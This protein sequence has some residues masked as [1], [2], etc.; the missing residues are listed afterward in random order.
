MAGRSADRGPGGLRRTVSWTR[1][2][3]SFTPRRLDR[4]RIVLAGS[5]AVVMMLFTVI[6]ASILACTVPLGT[7]TAQEGSSGAVP[8]G[9][10]RF[11]RSTSLAI[12]MDV[13]SRL[14]ARNIPPSCRATAVSIRPGSTTSLAFS[15]RPR[16]HNAKP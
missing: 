5:V 4:R 15:F 11:Y 1:A 16:E 7:T 8:S 12:S 2:L 6:G 13:C 14:K 9:L 3:W 10:K